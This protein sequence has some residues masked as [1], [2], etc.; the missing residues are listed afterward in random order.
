[1]KGKRCLALV[2]VS[3]M[4]TGTF[5]GCSGSTA[6]AGST[7]ASE[8]AAVSTAGDTAPA[9]SAAAAASGTFDW[10]KYSGT[11]IKVSLNQNCTGE[12]IIAKLPEFE[13]ATGIKVEHSITPEANYFDKVSTSLSSRSGDPDLFMSGP[14]QLWD[15][16]SAGYVEDLSTYLNDSN[17]MPSD[18]DFNDLIPAT[19]NALKW[20][21]TAGHKV[22]TGKQLALPMNFEIYS[23]AYNTEAFKKLNLQVPKTLDQL[24]TVSEKLKN[25]NGAGSYGLAIRGA[26]DW[27]TIHP[28]YMSE[29]TNYGAKDFEIKDGKLV[30]QVNS[31]E[32]VKMT[33]YWVDLIK[34]GCASS[35]AKYTWYEAGADLGAGKAAMLFDADNN[36]IQQ[37]WDG[38]SQEAGKIAWA[39]MPTVKEGDTANS[40]MWVWSMAMNANSKH[41][42]AAWYFLLYFT[43][44]E[45]FRYASVEGKNVDPCR[46]STWNDSGFQ[47]K[48]AKQPGYIDTY[49]KT[50]DKATILFTPQPSFF[51]TTTDWAETLQDIVAGKY[52][53]VQQG[54]DQLKTKMDK[55]VEDVEVQ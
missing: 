53:G 31:A 30:S 39:P 2:L 24:L 33:S 52:S 51:E 20:D 5:Y 3:A 12:A 22:G 29:F 8:T 45:F 42:D 38:A 41:K 9:A 44:K 48:M 13:K 21:G 14:Y 40:N 55:A 50:V 18:Y 26:R 4:L 28:A 7:A 36:G 6:S 11:T 15:Y 10:K 49:K 17:K 46:T 43:S 27:G 35:W 34:K 1:M 47:A 32:A 54:M 19:V 16:S 23:L 25:W 37:N